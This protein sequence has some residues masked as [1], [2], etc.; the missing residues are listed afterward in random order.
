MKY[1]YF[2]SNFFNMF[3]IRSICFS[4]FFP[5]FMHSQVTIFDVARSGKLEDIKRI[6][7]GNVNAINDVDQNGFSP[8]ILSCY[9]GNNTVAIYLLD[10][11]KDINYNSPNGTALMASVVKGN[12][13]MVK[14][15][16]QHKADVNAVDKMG[17]PALYYAIIFKNY[18]ILKLLLDANADKKLVNN[19]G[20]PMI[21]YAIN[22]N[23]AE[24]KK[25][26][27]ISN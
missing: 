5:V 25:I 16:I 17:N 14:K 21:F 11:V 9:K 2:W 23:D 6:E 27:K 7:Q 19:E 12:V 8:L 22:T 20:N 18:E 13:E 10:K 15:L 3:K 26:F 1:V 24:I 4:L